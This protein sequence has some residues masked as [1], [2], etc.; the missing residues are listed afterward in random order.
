MT[1]G[2]FIKS[3]EHGLNSVLPPVLSFKPVAKQNKKQKLHSVLP[4]YSFAT[5]PY[6]PQ[7]WANFCTNLLTTSQTA[8]KFEKL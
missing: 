3:T 4:H 8:G 2:E 6:F 1:F 7:L 5:P